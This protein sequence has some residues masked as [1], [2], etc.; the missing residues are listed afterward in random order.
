MAGGITKHYA[1]ERQ[2]RDALI[3][4]NGGY[5]KAVAIIKVDKGHPAGPEL[6]VLT[7]NAI[8]AVYNEYTRK[9]VTM[10][11]ARPGQIRQLTGKPNILDEGKPFYHWNIDHS[12]MKRAEYYEKNGM[13]EW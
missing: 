8:I 7:T 5:G 11:F 9:L 6:H 2:E 10:K 4:E 3:K 12:I 1:E 13:N